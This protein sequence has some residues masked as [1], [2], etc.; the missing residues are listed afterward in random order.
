MRA[1]SFFSQHLL[2]ILY[3][4][5][6]TSSRQRKAGAVRIFPTSFSL[7]FLFFLCHSVFSVIPAKAGI[8]SSKTI[9]GKAGFFHEGKQRKEDQK[10]IFTTENTENT[11]ITEIT[12]KNRNEVDDGNKEKRKPTEHR[13]NIG[14]RQNGTLL[15]LLHAGRLGVSL[16]PV[17]RVS[18]WQ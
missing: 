14:R 9:N 15:R 7:S 2:L 13:Q 12:E 17:E 4:W 1:W 10:R 6:Y 18:V 3:C 5:L 8:H 16:L 11:E